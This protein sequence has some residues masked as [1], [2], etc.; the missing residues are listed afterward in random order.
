M[1]HIKRPT[2]R[3]PPWCGVC[4]EQPLYPLREGFPTRQLFG[5][6]FHGFSPTWQRRIFFHGYK[7]ALTKGVPPFNLFVICIPPPENPTPSC[8]PN[9]EPLCVL[10]KR[11]VPT[12]TACR[13]HCLWSLPPSS[14]MSLVAAITTLLNCCCHRSLQ[15]PPPIRCRLSTINQMVIIILC[16]VI[17]ATLLSTAFPV[18]SVEKTT[19][20]IPKAFVADNYPAPLYGQLCGGGGGEVMPGE[21]HPSLW[22]GPQSVRL[23]WWKNLL[24]TDSRLLHNA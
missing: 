19:F 4:Q 11:S 9:L 14:T 13:V 17:D 6:Y 7:I 20:A 8:L 12:T 15:S 21:A 22:H 1:H 18:T 16:V 24:L 23:L 3:S 10:H 5:P 2:D